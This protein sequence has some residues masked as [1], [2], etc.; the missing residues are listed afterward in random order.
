MDEFSVFDKKDM[1]L[2]HL[3]LCFL[4]CRMFR[5]SLNPFKCAIAICREVLLGHVIFAK[6]M[7]VHIEK[8]KA[9]QA[10][11]SPTNLKEVVHS[12]A[13]LQGALWES[14]N[15]GHDDLKLHWL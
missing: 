13:F 6:G 9:I 7:L 5:L 8:I 12:S 11:A 2:E 4:R 10:V 15:L 14:V 3:R 1:H